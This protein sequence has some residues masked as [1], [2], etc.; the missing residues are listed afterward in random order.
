MNASLGAFIKTSDSCS[1]EK[2]FESFPSFQLFREPYFETKLHNIASEAVVTALLA[3]MLSFIVKGNLDDFVWTQNSSTLREQWSG[4][5][6]NA[7]A[8][9]YVDQAIHECG[10]EPW[11]LSLL[12]ALILAVH[13]LLIQAVRGRAWRYLGICVRS[14]YELNLHLV[15]SGKELGD[16]LEDRDQWAEDEERRRSWWAIWEMDVFAST[17]RRS[18]TAIDWSQNETFLPVNDEFW[19]RAEPQPSCVLEISPVD[20]WKTLEASGNQSAKAWFIVINSLMK[21]AQNISSPIGVDKSRSRRQHHATKNDGNRPSKPG[22]RAKDNTQESMNRLSILRNCLYCAVLALP[23]HLKYQYKSFSFGERSTDRHSM[24]SQ[25]LLHSS[26]YSI[27]MMTQLTKLMIY[28]YYIFRTGLRWPQ[29]SVEAP[30]LP[31]RSEDIRVSQRYALEQYLE[32]ADEI[33]ALVRRSNESQHRYV[34]PFL[35]NTI[36]LG[37]AVKIIH[38]EIAPAGSDKDLLNSDFELMYQTWSQFVKYWEMSTTLKKNL[39]VLESELH[40]VQ[41]SSS[42]HLDGGETGAGGSKAT[43]TNVIP[44]RSSLETSEPEAQYRGQDLGRSL[45]KGT[46]KLSYSRN[47]SEIKGSSR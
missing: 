17:I 38:R 26:I 23:P 19:S 14:A 3:S 40:D 2:Y 33:N 21:D 7:L 22:L 32:A 4:S 44:Y 43:A 41:N 15:D 34:N 5:H 12:Q 27:H 31:T 24:I 30:G 11:P 10:D 46:E 6:F 35:A 47:C 18:P 28:K 42:K 1:I 8:I 20:R 29:L 45:D 37:A 13:W 16:T 36:W 25:R 39:E 9:K